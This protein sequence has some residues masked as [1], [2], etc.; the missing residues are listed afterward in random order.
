M[1]G[2]SIDGGVRDFCS[3]TF[4]SMFLRLKPIKLSE[5]ENKLQLS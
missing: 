4:F 2:D 3:V 1:N 5:G